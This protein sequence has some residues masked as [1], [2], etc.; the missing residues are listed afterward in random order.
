MVKNLSKYL[1]NFLMLAFLIVFSSNVYSIFNNETSFKRII[2]CDWI[3]NEIFIVTDKLYS[4]KI[5]VN[6]AMTIFLAALWNAEKA[7]KIGTI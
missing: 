6:I 4:S 1:I 5:I 3:D 7:I 2:V